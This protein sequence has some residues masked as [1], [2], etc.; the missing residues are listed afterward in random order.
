MKE[1]RGIGK[2]ERR[3]QTESDEE[4]KVFCLWRI[5]AYGP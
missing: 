4:K 5:R 3:K 2:K 1:A